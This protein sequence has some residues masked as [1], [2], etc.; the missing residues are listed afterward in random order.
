[1][2]VLIADQRSGRVAAAHAGWRGVVRGI[3]RVTVGSLLKQGSQVK[4]L[5]AA[6]GPHISVAAF[7]V[8]EEVALEL[9]SAAPGVGAVVRNPGAKPRVDLRRLVRAQLTSLGFAEAAVDD[10]QGC[11]VSDADL[12]F[13]YRRDGAASGRHLSAVV[14]RGA[15]G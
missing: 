13:S 1:V 7:E 14:A 4:D 8:S 10:V 9:A 15:D 5:L 11:T 2:P 6:V 12:F 3:V